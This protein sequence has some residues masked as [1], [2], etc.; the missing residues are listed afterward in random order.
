MRPPIPDNLPVL[1]DTALHNG[2]DY[3]VEQHH[4]DGVWGIVFDA[5]NPPAAPVH[6]AWDTHKTGIAYRARIALIGATKCL[7][8]DLI[9]HMTRRRA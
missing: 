3:R 4:Q 8:R 9:E 1:Q 5:V 6:I 7:Y 2:W